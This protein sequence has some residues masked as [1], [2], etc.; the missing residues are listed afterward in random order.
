MPLK[1]KIDLN[2]LSAIEDKSIQKRKIT[3]PIRWV[4]LPGSTHLLLLLSGKCG[5]NFPQQPLR[6]LQTGTIHGVTDAGHI[7][8]N[9]GFGVEIVVTDATAAI[10]DG[11]PSVGSTTAAAATT[12]S[13]I[14]ACQEGWRFI[15]VSLGSFQLRKYLGDFSLFQMVPGRKE[16]NR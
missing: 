10:I 6:R 3:T 8:A 16:R 4:A 7:L 13:I 9:T 2:A 12:S 14:G 5:G 15:P 11:R 1:F